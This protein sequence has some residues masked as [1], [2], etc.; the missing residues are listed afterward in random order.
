MNAATLPREPTSL[1]TNGHH[2]MPAVKETLISNEL[3][4]MNAYLCE[5]HRLFTEG[6]A[7]KGD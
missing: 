6:L 7:L 2:A 3:R 5:S 1:K 4:K